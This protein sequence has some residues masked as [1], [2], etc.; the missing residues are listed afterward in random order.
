MVRSCDNTRTSGGH[1]QATLG[2][3]LQESNIQAISCVASQNDAAR[4]D[5]MFTI[6]ATPRMRRVATRYVNCELG[7]QI[8]KSRPCVCTYVCTY[9]RVHRGGA[10]ASR[11]HVANPYEYVNKE[12]SC[13][14]Y[15]R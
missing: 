3:S 4:R 15:H 8:K 9:V 11:A 12:S 13:I 2:C 5:T 10:T 6:Y 7:R 1:A 14:F